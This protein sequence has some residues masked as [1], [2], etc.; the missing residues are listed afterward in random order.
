MN[1]NNK[2]VYSMNLFNFQQFL[3]GASFVTVGNMS[4]D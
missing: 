3:K 1:F 4:R 2:Q